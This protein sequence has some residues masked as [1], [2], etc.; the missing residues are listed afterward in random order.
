[1]SLFGENISSALEKITSLIPPI[2]LLSLPGIFITFYYQ[3]HHGVLPYFISKYSLAE[4]LSVSFSSIFLFFVLLVYGAIAGFWLLYLLYWLIYGFMSL[5]PSWRLNRTT[6]FEASRVIPKT[7]TEKGLYLLTSLF[8]CFSLIIA[9]FLSN[10]SAQTILW[11][12]MALGLFVLLFVDRF[13]QKPKPQSALD[14]V[15]NKDG[16]RI[17]FLVP[18]SV[19]ICLLTLL[20][21]VGTSMANMFVGTLGFRTGGSEAVFISDATLSKIHSVL[22]L[23]GIVPDICTVQIDGR[24]MSRISVNTKLDGAI[25]L[26]TIWNDGSEHRLIG[27]DFPVRRDPHNF[28]LTPIFVDDKEVVE[29]A[30]N[31][32]QNCGTQGGS[33][34][35]VAHY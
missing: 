9:V 29:L 15:P 3:C 21:G 16:R 32:L 8:V 33:P 35:V 25:P 2:S 31:H 30:T 22:D 1:M 19:A 6:V 17:L 13:P 4:A 28:F 24:S 5:R 10:H 7:K 26:I 34:G 23:Y 20:P 14:T 12:F 18:I 27:F 11:Y